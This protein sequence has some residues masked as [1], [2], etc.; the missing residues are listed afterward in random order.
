MDLGGA[1]QLGLTLLRAHLQS[2]DPEQHELA[3][4]TVI[5]DQIKQLLTMLFMLLT[6]SGVNRPREVGRA[7][8]WERSRGSVDL[9]GAART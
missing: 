1:W 2:A 4:Y 5:K 7:S 8:G 9:S 6:L 3:C